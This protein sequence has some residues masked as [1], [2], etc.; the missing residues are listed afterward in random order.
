MSTTLEVGL[1]SGKTTA[2]QVGLDETV[3]MLRERAQVALG[4]GKGLLLDSR[5]DVLDGCATIREARV[6]NG[7]IL[8]IQLRRRQVQR[9]YDA[10][11]AVLGD[12]SAVTWGN[13]T[14][15]VD[16]RAVKGLLKNVQQ[17]QSSDG[18]FAAVRG[19]GSVV[20]WGVSGRGGDSSAV[21]N[22]LKNV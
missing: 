20:T 9:A 19:D 10:F 4:V 1:L 17:V 21:Q 13:A 8:I 3:D 15:W 5:G 12:G 18:A 22:Q 14:D 16:S 7:D 11:A 6:Q 2:V